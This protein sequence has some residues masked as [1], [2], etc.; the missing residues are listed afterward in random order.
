MTHGFENTGTV[1][2][3]ASGDH[4]TR[5]AAPEPV[6][7]V[8][9]GSIQVYQITLR[10]SWVAH[11]GGD[12]QGR[13]E[14]M[15]GKDLHSDYDRF[16]RGSGVRLDERDVSDRGDGLVAQAFVGP[17]EESA[18]RTKERSRTFG[19]TGQRVGHAPVQQRWVR[20]QARERRGRRPRH[21]MIDEI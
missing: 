8:E 3:E 12:R 19:D 6:Q 16:E 11:D 1:T 18:L 7:D 13:I 4:R 10:G 15:G 17:I 9:L 14:I 5:E 21:P 2:L 20:R